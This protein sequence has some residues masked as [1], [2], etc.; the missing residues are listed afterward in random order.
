M[1]WEV[2]LNQ[3]YLDE[4]HGWK[5]VDKLGKI[6]IEAERFQISIFRFAVHEPFI[7]RWNN[8]WISSIAKSVGDKLKQN[9]VQLISAIWRPPLVLG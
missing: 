8:I 2:Y 9:K 4:Y 1:W 3:D 7:R 6:C 5:I